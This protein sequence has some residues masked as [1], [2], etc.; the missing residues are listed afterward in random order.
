MWPIDSFTFTVKDLSGVEAERLNRL[1]WDRSH[2]EQALWRRQLNNW[3]SQLTAVWPVEL[4]LRIFR[5]D[6]SFVH[7]RFQN[8][9]I[10]LVYWF[11]VMDC[12]PLPRTVQKNLCGIRSVLHSK[13]TTR[14]DVNYCRSLCVCAVMDWHTVQDVTSSWSS[15]ARIGSSFHNNHREGSN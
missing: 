8:V 6:I 3:Q 14:V 5:I 15:S 1:H 2:T 9:G 13:L 7:Y 4:R 10:C 12:L 11:L